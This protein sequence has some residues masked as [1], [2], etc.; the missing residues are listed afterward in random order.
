MPAAPVRRVVV[1]VMSRPLPRFW[2]CWLEETNMGNEH[3]FNS[4]LRS[5][6]LAAFYH[7]NRRYV[8]ASLRIV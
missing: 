2:T 7:R 3:P 8:N 1:M 5:V 4:T 6:S